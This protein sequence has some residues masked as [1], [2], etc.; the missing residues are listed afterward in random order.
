MHK[1][2][3]RFAREK[4]KPNI[5]RRKSAKGRWVYEIT[6][7][8]SDGRDRRQTVQGGLREAETA[9]ATVKSRMGRGDRVAPQPRL[10]LAVAAGE[11]M[12]A[13]SPN[14]TPKTVSTYRYGLDT[15]LLPE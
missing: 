12:T 1:E 4:V 11:W 9:L 7:K 15:H 10:T 14:L 6:F 2:S 3:S 13:K 8:D 5:W